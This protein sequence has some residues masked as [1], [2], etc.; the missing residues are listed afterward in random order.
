MLAT[1]VSYR[2]SFHPPDIQNIAMIELSKTH[3][4]Q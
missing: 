4:K 1:L 2:G 3:G